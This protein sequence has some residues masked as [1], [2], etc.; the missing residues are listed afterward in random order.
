MANICC[1]VLVAKG[2]PV[3]VK[4]FLHEV[5]GESIID[6]NKI[7]PLDYD[8]TESRIMEWGTKWNAYEPCFIDNKPSD[9]PIDEVKIYFDSAW[10][11][12]CAIVEKLSKQYLLAF[13]LYYF[14][15]GNLFAGEYF[16]ENG[17]V[18]DSCYDEGNNDF[19][20]VVE[21]WFGE[22]EDFYPEDT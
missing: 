9:K 10:Q 4:R 5:H 21:E 11:P 20:R 14:E 1:N 6:F 3:E 17:S 18:S 19:R 16:A 15:P 7:S 22:W 12:P 8:T 2:P 13:E